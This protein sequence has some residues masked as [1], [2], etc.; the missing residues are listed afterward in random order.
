V[1]GR[2][3]VWRTTRGNIGILLNNGEIPTDGD[4]RKKA[5][6]YEYLPPYEALRLALRIIAVVLP[7]VPKA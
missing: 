4:Q 6:R 2:A 3:K 5:N 1:G 7:T